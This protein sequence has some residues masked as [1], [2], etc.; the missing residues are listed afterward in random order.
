[1]Y[2]LFWLSQLVFSPAVGESGARSSNMID[3]VDSVAVSG[4][5]SVHAARI[6]PNRGEA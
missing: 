1:M 2:G 3:R 6:R 5:N 4:D